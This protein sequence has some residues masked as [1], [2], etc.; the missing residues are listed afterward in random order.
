MTGGALALEALISLLVLAGAF[1]T[2][3]GSIGLARFP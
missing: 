3:A 1:F 2:L